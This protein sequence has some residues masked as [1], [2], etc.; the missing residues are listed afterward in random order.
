MSRKSE[1][2]LFY[3]RYVD[4]CFLI[5][6]ASDI[7]VVFNTFNNFNKY[8][9]FTLEEEKELKLNFLD[10]TIIRK[11]KTHPVTG[12]YQKPT[13]TG[14][15]INFNSHHPLN[16]KKALVYNLTDKVLLLSSSQ[17]HKKK[18][19]LITQALLRNN[20]PQQFIKNH[21]KSTH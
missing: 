15:Y 7:D 13:A 19:D 10:L 17:F 1:S 3:R 5:V 18:F 4:D 8:L 14:R 20:Y 16:M 2:V 6:K 12:W 9:L 11:K 21:I